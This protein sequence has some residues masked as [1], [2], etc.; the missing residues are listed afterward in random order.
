MKQYKQID[1]IFLKYDIIEIK[2]K[3][4]EKIWIW[5]MDIKR[6]QILIIKHYLIKIML[7]KVMLY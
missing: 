1:T 5:N 7:F 2:E 3:Y 4:N 6:K